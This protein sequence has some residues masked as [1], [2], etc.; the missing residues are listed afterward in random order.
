MGRAAVEYRELRFMI[1]EDLT[2]VYILCQVLGD[3][4]IGI[5]GWHHKSFYQSSSAIDILEM[6]RLG[7]E[8][9]VLWPLKAPETR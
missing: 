6:I 7:K 3:C 1:G 2:D 5:Q 8:D 4:P 9:P